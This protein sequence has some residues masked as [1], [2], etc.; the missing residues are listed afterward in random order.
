[1][2]TPDP[3]A[4]F[5]SERTVIK[6]KPRTPAGTPPPAAAPAPFFG[7]A[8]P[9]PAVD[10]AP[11]PKPAPKEDTSAT[12]AV[13]RDEG[14]RL[15]LELGFWSAS[16]EDPARMNAGSPSLIPLG[17]DVSWHTS[18]RVLLGFHGHAARV[19]LELQQQWLVGQSPVHAQRGHVHGL[20]HRGHHVGHAP[21]DALQRR[22]GHVLAGSS[23]V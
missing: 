2:T 23:A 6:P 1:M 21:G 17:A 8:D 7:G 10:P 18:R 4:A 9:T 22:A 14:M 19:G 16:G 3:F 15:A 5:E 11:T 13:V 20:L 12:P